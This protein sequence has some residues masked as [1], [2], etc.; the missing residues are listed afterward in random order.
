MKNN[1][2]SNPKPRIIAIG[3]TG[4]VGKRVIELLSDRYTFHVAS[5][6]TKLDITNLDSFTS[7]SQ[8]D[9]D[10]V[11]L[12][13]AKTD[14]DGCEKDKEKGKNGDAWRINVEGA[15]NAA[16]YCQNKNKKLI[17]IS[18]DFVFDGKKG[19][20]K[21]D[22]TPNPLNW[23]GFTK[24]EGERKVQNSAATHLILR[25]AY[26]YG[27]TSTG[28]DFVTVI[29]NRLETGQYVNA[30]EDHIFTPTFIDDFAHALDILMKRNATGIYHIV[31]SSSHTPYE[32]ACI[33]ADFFGLDST[34]IT[35]TTR[36]VF[37]ANRA[38]R[39]FN[40][41]LKNDKIQSIGGSMKTFEDGIR[42]Y[43]DLLAAS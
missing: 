37:F 29:K 4:L 17:Y 30:V 19:N 14:V 3:G 5:R 27:A 25:L 23:Y 39:P 43:K 32:A 28:R 41:S 22:D 7:L 36:G 31:G 42:A 21:E 8:F 10:T 35:K 34:L 40:L 18:T 12:L 24:Y 38:E 13:A 20:Y 1:M 16:M 33:I 15:S 6:A 2:E 9:A 26:P 11:L